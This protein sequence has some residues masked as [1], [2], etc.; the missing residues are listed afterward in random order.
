MKIF[1]L[2]N[3]VLCS[4]LC[5]GQFDLLE[6]VGDSIIALNRIEKC[7]EYPVN[8]SDLYFKNYP[9]GHYAYYDR[10]GHV[11][12]RNSYSTVYGKEL[13]EEEFLVYY[14]NDS[15][16]KMVSYIWIFPNSD[17]KLM[18]VRVESETCDGKGGYLEIHPG[19][20]KRPRFE[21]FYQQSLY[22]ESFESKQ[23]KIETVYKDSTKTKKEYEERKYLTNDHLDSIVRFQ[24]KLKLIWVYNKSNALA[25]FTYLDQFDA[26]SSRKEILYKDKL[27]IGIQYWGL[28]DGK[29]FVQRETRF[30]FQ[31]YKD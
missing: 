27:P 3:F 2:L 11:V 4:K 17:T 5:F 12:N 10:Q 29:W 20:I 13:N 30:K 23:Y 18:R 15:S 26:Y 1:T 16:G 28:Q 19:M 21:R 22:S 7:L 25:S 6:G 8:D 24:D 31:F 9:N 14:L